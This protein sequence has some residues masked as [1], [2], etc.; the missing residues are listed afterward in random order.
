VRPKQFAKLPYIINCISSIDEI[1]IFS[2]GETTARTK[3]ASI[4]TKG[5]S[6][7]YRLTAYAGA[8]SVRGPNYLNL[9]AE[10][11]DRQYGSSICEPV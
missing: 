3:N 10:P 1:F 2:F 8:M 4:R 9:K 5:G 7:T 6:D 11:T